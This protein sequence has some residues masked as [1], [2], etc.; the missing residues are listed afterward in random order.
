MVISYVLLRFY[1]WKITVKP[2]SVAAPQTFSALQVAAPMVVVMVIKTDKATSPPASNAKRFEADPGGQIT[3]FL[4]W[5]TKFWLVVYLPLWKIL[6]NGKDDNPYMK[7]KIKA[8]FQTTN[9]TK[10]GTEF[11]QPVVG[12]HHH[13][14]P[15]QNFVNSLPPLTPPIRTM[16]TRKSSQQC[17][18]LTHHFSWSCYPLVNVYITMENHHL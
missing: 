13:T 9:Q 6:V 15:A 7:W 17:C 18:W 16:P 5:F 8:M 4:G 1:S 11:H 12:A 10:F 3:T 14:S 2:K